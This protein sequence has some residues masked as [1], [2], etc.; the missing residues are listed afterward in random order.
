MTK[1]SPATPLEMFSYKKPDLSHLRVFGC[2]VMAYVPKD[3]RKKWD[4][5]SIP[6]VLVDHPECFK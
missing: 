4:A 1:V 5:K 6:C 3:K 2:K